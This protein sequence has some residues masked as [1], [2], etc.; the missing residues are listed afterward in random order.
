MAIALKANAIAPSPNAHGQTSL[1]R[2][3]IIV[4]DVA[5]QTVAKE[6]RQIIEVRV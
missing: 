1:N 3:K 5:S 6:R 4:K 2:K